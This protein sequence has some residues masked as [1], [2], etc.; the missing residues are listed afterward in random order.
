MMDPAGQRHDLS[1]RSHDI[2][3]GAVPGASAP[4]SSILGKLGLVVV[5]ALLGSGLTFAGIVYSRP[6]A[7][8]LPGW[9]ESLGP[10]VS[11]KT[12]RAGAGNSPKSDDVVLL[13]YSMGIEGSATVIDSGKQVPMPLTGVIPGIQQAVIRM[14][15]GGKYRARVPARLGYG[16]RAAGPIPANSDLWFEVELIDFI[17]QADY[18]AQMLRQAGNAS[19]EPAPPPPGETPAHK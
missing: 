14:Q 16:D 8:P 15:K 9:V 10:Q 6:G 3:L 13:N 19:V 1:R 17:T 5:G 18:E 4:R 12:L 7:L 11:V 2:L